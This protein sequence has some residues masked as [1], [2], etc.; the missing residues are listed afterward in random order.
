MWSKWEKKK[1]PIY[2][3]DMEWNFIRKFDTTDDFG[4]YCNKDR[5]YIYH[6]LK[7]CKKIRIKKKWYKISRKE[8]EK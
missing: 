6:N 7:Y 8:I 4:D 2:L 1:K 3:Y 5:S